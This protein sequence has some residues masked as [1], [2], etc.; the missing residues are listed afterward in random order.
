VTNFG[1]VNVDWR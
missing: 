1:E